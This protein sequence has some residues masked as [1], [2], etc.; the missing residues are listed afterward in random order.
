[1]KLTLILIAEAVC[2]VVLVIL[3]MIEAACV[4]IDKRKKKGQNDVR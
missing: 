1:M 4:W 3:W 2:A